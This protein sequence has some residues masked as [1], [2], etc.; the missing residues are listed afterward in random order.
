MEFV[1]KGTG[2]TDYLERAEIFLGELH[3]RPSRANVFGGDISVSDDRK[4]GMRDT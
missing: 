2:L 1:G 3:G 4:L